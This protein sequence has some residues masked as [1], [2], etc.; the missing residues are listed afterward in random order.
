[1]FRGSRFFHYTDGL[2]HCE[3]VSLD[4]L[5]HALGTPLYVY[6]RA[7]L[8]FNLESFENALR[9]VR[10][11]TFYAVKANFNLAILRWFNQAGCS[12]DVVS[13]GELHRVERSGAPPH[14]IAFGGV[15]K[16]SS[17]L[18]EAIQRGLFCIHAESV[19]EVEKLAELANRL[20]SAAR[21]GLR[22]NPEIDARTHPYI[23]TGRR[24]DKFG[25]D[26][27]TLDRVLS[28]IR[29]ESRLRLIS[30][31][32]H[33]GSQIL[34]LEPYRQSFLKLLALAE[35]LRGEGFDIRNIDI[36]GGFGIPQQGEPPFDLA[37]LGGFLREHQGQYRVL[38]EPGRYLVGNAGIL[39]TRVLYRK[40]K[41]GRRFLLVD[42]GM[43]DFMRPT[44]YGAY[45]G[46][47][48][49]RQGLPE[50]RGD[51]AGPVCESGD[52]F[53]L[54]RDLPDAEPGEL[55]A[56]ENTGAYGSVLT[57][58]YNARRRPAEVLVEGDSFRVIRR[59]ETLEDLIRLEEE[60][61]SQELSV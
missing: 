60:S 24:E 5:A 9:E 3:G 4:R 36:G 54:D 29:R 23:A 28:A 32:S 25:I 31:G 21:V 27:E 2:L 37:A 51:L 45:H 35:R 17:E 55:L 52:F 61:A 8:D 14:R 34:D 50:M 33:I 43:S 6:S 58:N 22:I 26:I 40:A 46:V 16:T 11:R 44:L 10:H 18:E 20:N 39:V 15:A 48:A 56:I 59:R 57:H 13:S 42:A 19:E 38:F 12:F 49:L 7:A 41:Q 53:A 1:M 30:I 47:A